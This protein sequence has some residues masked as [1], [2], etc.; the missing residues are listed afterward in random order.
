M[1]NAALAMLR[2]ATPA[3]HALIADH[4]TLLLAVLLGAT[5]LLATALFVVPMLVAR[6]FRGTPAIAARYGAPPI[7][8]RLRSG[9]AA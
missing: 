7:V 9:H 2:F 1:L 8:G 4:V 5:G 6:R 3:A